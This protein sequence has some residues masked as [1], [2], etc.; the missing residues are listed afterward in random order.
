MRSLRGAVLALLV[1]CGGRGPAGVDSAATTGV[2]SRTIADDPSAIIDADR[3]VVLGIRTGM[4]LDSV[5]LLLGAPVREGADLS[6]TLDPVT[7]LEYPMGTV[8]GKGT[9]GVISFLCGG[10]QCATAEGV[11]IGDSSDVLLGTYG[12]TPPRGPMESPEALD[13]RLGTAPCNLTFTLSSG[14]VTSLELS[15][16]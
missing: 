9:T 5:K 2:A 7:V 1:A 15:C 11:G 16:S 12:P 3:G 4:P 8:Q 6:D 10:D 14:R 13:Y